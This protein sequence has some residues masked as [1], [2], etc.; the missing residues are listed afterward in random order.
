MPENYD[1]IR[2]ALVPHIDKADVIGDHR[3]MV[4]L[5]QRFVNAFPPK[6]SPIEKA[7][8]EVFRQ[9]LIKAKDEYKHICPVCGATMYDTLCPDDMIRAMCAPC[10]RTYTPMG[11]IDDD[12][13]GKKWFAKLWDGG[14]EPSEII[15][16][17]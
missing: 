17:A 8:R 12:D 3:V 1:N 4:I 7:V 6:I 5:C 16:V 13:Y 2:A 9:R 11:Y 14:A 15:E 10:G